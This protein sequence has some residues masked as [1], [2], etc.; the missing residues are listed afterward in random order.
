MPWQPI[1]CVPVSSVRVGCLWVYNVEK[2]YMPQRVLV[3]LGLGYRQDRFQLI[4]VV[5]TGFCACT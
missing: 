1:Q 4:S 3:V 5:S 2:I